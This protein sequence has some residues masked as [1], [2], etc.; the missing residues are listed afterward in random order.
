MTLYLAELWKVKIVSTEL[1]KIEWE[2]W[3][4]LPYLQLTFEFSYFVDEMGFNS[5]NFTNNDK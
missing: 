2:F 3:D 1:W 5:F 4:K